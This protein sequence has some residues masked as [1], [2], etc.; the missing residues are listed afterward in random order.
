[1]MNGSTQLINKQESGPGLM[2]FLGTVQAIGTTG[3][4]GNDL[5][6]ISMDYLF[7]IIGKLGLCNSHCTCCALPKSM[8]VLLQGMEVRPC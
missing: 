7:S 3:T 2:C 6:T 5:Q 8:P 1:M 4:K